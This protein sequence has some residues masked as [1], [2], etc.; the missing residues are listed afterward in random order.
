M[1][2]NLLFFLL[3]LPAFGTTY[4]VVNQRSDFESAPEYKAIMEQ[5][6]PYGEFAKKTETPVEPTKPK[7]MSQGQRMVEEAKARNRAMIAQ[8]RDE[9]KKMMDQKSESGMSEM[10]RLKLETQKVQQG[11][12]QEVKDS[13]AQWKRE[14]DIFL[15]R[16]K[17]YKANTFVIPAP[18]EVIVEKKEI[19]ALP[20]AY[21]IGGAFSVP[22]RDQKDRP[23]CSAFTAIRSI[24]II[25]AQNNIERDLSEQYFYWA[26]KPSCQSSP[27]S[28]KGSWI[29]NGLD[30]SKNQRSVDIPTEQNCAYSDETVVKNETQLP[31]TSGCKTGVAKVEAYEAVKTLSDLITKLKNNTPVVLSAKLTPNFY[32]NS[33]LIT[34]AD[35]NKGRDKLDGHSLGHAF[36]AVGVIELPQKLLATEGRYCIVVTNSWGKG[37][38]AGGY[39][40]VTEN[41]LLKNRSQNSFVA[42]TKV[43]AN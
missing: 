28:E 8:M 1:K 7:E 15:G 43:S 19:P 37:W 34:L 5:L 20:D 23:T 21:I 30:Y 11:W 39:S 3:S 18:K 13:L 12:K 25:L 38:G 27:C 9:E 26:S 6:K 17:V 41:W 10:D 32:L 35:E 36:L 16:I 2:K 42:V 31:M 24:E 29:V 4:S 33:G 40:C 14:Q 22:V